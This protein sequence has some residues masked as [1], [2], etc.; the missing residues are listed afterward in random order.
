MSRMVQ[1]G[2]VFICIPLRIRDNELPNQL[3]FNSISSRTSLEFI[4]R[5]GIGYSFDPM[6]PGQTLTDRYAKS[7]RG[8]L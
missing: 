5:N 1:R 4:G 6:L 3:D 7:I 8:L 2:F